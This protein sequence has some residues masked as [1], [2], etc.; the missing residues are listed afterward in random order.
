MPWTL[1]YDD[2]PEG[3]AQRDTHLRWIQDRSGAADDIESIGTLDVRQ[4]GLHI[5]FRDETRKTRDRLL[6]DLYQQYGVETLERRVVTPGGFR[7]EALE[8]RV[9]DNTW[10]RRL[11]DHARTA[12]GA[13]LVAKMAVQQGAREA[14]GWVR[15]RY[16]NLR[17]RFKYGNAATPPPPPAA[18]TQ[19]LIEETPE[20]VEAWV[21]NANVAMIIVGGTADTLQSRAGRIFQAYEREFRREPDAN[22]LEVIRS[23]VLEQMG[24]SPQERAHAQTRLEQVQSWIRDAQESSLTRGAR[25]NLIADVL[26]SPDGRQRLAASMVQPL[27]TRIDY[28]STARRT[29]LVDPLPEGALPSYGTD[30]DVARLAM[31]VDANGSPVEEPMPTRNNA[32]IA[33]SS[34][35]IRA[36]AGSVISGGDSNSISV[37]PS[38]AFIGGEPLPVIP[39]WVQVGQR[40]RSGPNHPVR[41]I[42]GNQTMD[43]HIISIEGYLV[44]VR[45]EGSG[46]VYDCAR[47]D[48]QA[49]WELHPSVMAPIQGTLHVKPMPSVWDRL[50]ESNEI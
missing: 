39:A 33:G 24:E 12:V 26:R 27:R 44:R 43:A 22:V 20:G 32:I 41:Q 7:T 48:F 40:I 9:Q 11:G 38:N 37:G 13:A 49:F 46:A 3:R 16:E 47:S 45:I 4:V 25:E 34:N 31:G 50:L 23:V 6:L 17:F 19:S 28:S 14:S 36:T 21:R 18:R 5:V 10:T 35:T 2:S 29:L 15:D 42:N 1:R 8:R 30:L